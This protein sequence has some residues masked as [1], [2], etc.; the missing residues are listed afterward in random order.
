MFEPL[1]L[2]ALRDSNSYKAVLSSPAPVRG[3]LR[4]ENDG[5]WLIQKFEGKKSEVE[6]RM[7]SRLYAPEDRKL[8]ATRDFDYS[9][10]ADEATAEAGVAAA[11]RALQRLLNDFSAFVADTASKLAGDCLQED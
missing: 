2:D 5:L 7:S 9:E 8:V 11:D 6:L 1:L 10:P 3:D 4:I